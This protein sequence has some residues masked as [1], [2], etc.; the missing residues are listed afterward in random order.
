MAKMLTI[1]LDGGLCNGTTRVLS[2]SMVDAMQADYVQGL[3]V[4]YSADPGHDYGMS[5][6]HVYPETGTPTMVHDF[7]LYGAVPWIDKTCG[8][9][10]F[11]LIDK[12]A[13]GAQEGLDI[14]DYIVNNELITQPLGCPSQTVAF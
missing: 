9:A 2:Q 12:Q 5:W 7:G 1:D 13:Q 6:W 11:L 3:T 8:Y 14:M 4:F 10:A